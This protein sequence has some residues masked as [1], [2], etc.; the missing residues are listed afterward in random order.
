ML[1][2]H[3]AYVKLDTVVVFHDALPYQQATAKYHD[4]NFEQLLLFMR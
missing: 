1:N 2:K 3:Q 4:D